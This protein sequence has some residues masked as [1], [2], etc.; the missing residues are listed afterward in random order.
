MEVAV[1]FFVVGCRWGRTV[2]NRDLLPAEGQTTR[3]TKESTQLGKS[4]GS[5]LMVVDV[6]LVELLRT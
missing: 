4:A 2:Q 5:Q 6:D 1:V 3:S